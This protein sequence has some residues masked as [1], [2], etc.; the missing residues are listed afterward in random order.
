MLIGCATDQEKLRA[1]YQTN[2]CDF[3]RS[4]PH[5]F[6]SH[7]DNHGEVVEG[8]FVYK[9]D[10]QH[11]GIASVLAVPVDNVLRA[12][13]EGWGICCQWALGYVPNYYC[14][15]QYCREN[16]GHSLMGVAGLARAPDRE[17]AEN[18]ALKNCKAAI[19][20]FADTVG[21]SP[22]QLALRC[23]IQKFEWCD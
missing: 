3:K 14:G 8:D 6:I 18:M 22:S 4:Q 11:K 10:A 15:A 20:Q 16:V 2:L 1:Q 7:V 13:R 19:R 17:Q 21:S 12:P 23:K 5:I 9:V